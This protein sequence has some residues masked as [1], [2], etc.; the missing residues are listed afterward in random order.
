MK[1]VTQIT[2]L[3]FVMALFLL[4][5]ANLS[6]AKV[7]L[8]ISSPAF[9]KIPVVVNPTEDSTTKKI[10]DIF[11]NDL[12]LTG[13]FLIMDIKSPGAE[14][15]VEL[16]AT[17]SG[18]ITATMRAVDFAEN[19]DI[20]N[21]RYEASE[22]LLRNLA[23]T[24]ANDFFKAVTG[25]STIFRCK[26]AFLEESGGTRKIKIV[27]WDGYD[28]K[29][30]L[31]TQSLIVTPRWHID[32]KYPDSS[33]IGYSKSKNG[34]WDI[35]Q[36]N[37]RTKKEIGLY[38]EEG[39]NLIGGYSNNGWMFFSSSQS[40]NA[41]IYKMSLGAREAVRLT[42]SK[43]I[44]VSPSVTA[45]GSQVAFVSDRSGKPQ[46]YIMSASGEPAQRVTMSG[47]YNT[48]PA[49]SP[50]GKALAYV[51]RVGGQHQIFLLKGASVT[52]LTDEGN[53]EHPAFSPDGL[54][55]AFDSDRQGGKGIY[56]MRSD[57]GD[58][59]RISRGGINSSPTWSPVY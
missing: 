23:H 6:Y 1:K 26:L 56:I 59:R 58:V 40:G 7:Y 24:M 25:L 11:V 54:F 47:D 52:Q 33:Y 12:N 57:G 19:T 35:Y 42:N 46:V 2:I 36:L 10:R 15:Q 37:L 45:D 27:D 32:S 13:R 55:I 9:R 39:L 14:V 28:E 38:V 21:K 22:E 17:S 41:E 4:V 30:V 18:K 29:V 34:K 44:N 5:D 16:Q 48:S 3:V 8:D 31:S 20:I 51:G 53:N 43:A 49:W 50:D